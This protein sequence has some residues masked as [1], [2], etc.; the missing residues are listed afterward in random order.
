MKI[1]FLGDTHANL[2]WF[3]TAIIAAN[4]MECE[5]IVQVGDFGY[6]PQLHE[7]QEFLRNLQTLLEM[8]E[9]DCDWI[10]GNHEDHLA[11]ADLDTE[12][13]GFIGPRLRHIARGSRWVWD[14]KVFLA[15]GGAWSIDRAA[16]TKYSGHYGW[17]PQETITSA[18]MNTA[19]DGGLC[20]VLVVHD[21][22]YGGFISEQTQPTDPEC[23]TNMRCVDTVMGHT[24]P[25]LLV[26]GHHH[27]RYTETI[28]NTLIQGLGCDDDLGSI[29][30]V[31]TEHLKG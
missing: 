22:P 21:A 2:A 7:G 8:Y 26:H 16:R 28:D 15:L 9:M 30:V 18:Q 13:R 14:D 19:I 6:W 12:Y 25:E 24:H 5:K 23:V 20:D 10:D 27:Y 29:L 11:L 3:N 31:D 17:F 1:M 4:K